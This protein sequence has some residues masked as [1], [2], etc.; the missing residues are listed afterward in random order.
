M[1][2]FVNNAF[3]NLSTQHRQENFFKDHGEFV[4]PIEITNE[5]TNI[6]CIIPFESKLK[7]LLSVPEA[8]GAI[9]SEVEREQNNILRARGIKSNLTDGIYIKDAIEKQKERRI[10]QRQQQ[11]SAHSESEATLYFALYYDDI[12]IVN[13]I[14]SARKKHKLG[15]F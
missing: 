8:F 2:L 9:N 1:K 14:G 7:A 15:E 11:E 10:L 12:E 5:G 13:A 4:Q 6:G 3:D